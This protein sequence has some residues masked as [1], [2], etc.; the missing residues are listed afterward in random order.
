MFNFKYVEDKKLAKVGVS[1]F[2]SVL[3]ASGLH[4][5]PEPIVAL[6]RSRLK[7][8]FRSVPRDAKF[9]LMWDTMRK[10]RGHP[11]G[12]CDMECVHWLFRLASISKTVCTGGCQCGYTHPKVC[13]S[14]AYVSGK[15]KEMAVGFPYSQVAINASSQDRDSDLWARV[16]KCIGLLTTSA[17]VTGYLSAIAPA[18]Q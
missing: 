3:Y 18:S 6:I 16:S 13:E 11:P 7:L 1:E 10:E 15:V 8:N 12:C 17:S 9:H 2:L 5:V 14:V 4:Y